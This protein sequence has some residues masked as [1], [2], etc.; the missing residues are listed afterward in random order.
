MVE[1]REEGARKTVMGT[2]NQRYAKGVPEN[3]IQ[4]L[5]SE[6][7][8]R[9]LVS[10]IQKTKTCETKYTLGG[11]VE[12]ELI[13]KSLSRARLNLLKLS[14]LQHQMLLRWFHDS[15]K[16][17]NLVLRY[18]FDHGWHKEKYLL[19][20]EFQPNK[21]K[22]MLQ[23]M[24]VSVE[25][26]QEQKSRYILLRTPK[27]IRQQ[28]VYSLVAHLKTQSTKLK[29]LRKAYP[30]KPMVKFVLKYKEK[31]NWDSDCIGIERRS[32]RLAMDGKSF[33]LYSTIDPRENL[34]PTKTRFHQPVRQPRDK[35]DPMFQVIRLAFMM[36]PADFE[37]DMKICFQKGKFYLM[38]SRKNYYWWYDP[39]ARHSERTNVCY[40]RIRKFLTIY[41]PCGSAFVIG[42]NVGN[43]LDKCIRRIDRTKKPYIRKRGSYDLMKGQ[44][45]KY[46]KVK[47]RVQLYKLRRAYHSAEVKAKNVVRDFHYKAAH[48]LCRRFSQVFFPKF[49]AKSIAQLSLNHNVKR[50]LNMLSFYKFKNRL[51]QTASLYNDTCIKTGSEAYTSKQCGLCGCLNDKLGASEI[52]NCENCGLTSD[53]DLHA[54]RNILLKY[55]I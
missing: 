29:K 9:F 28:A 20:D 23:K 12:K 17:Y 2:T 48:F 30:D 36:N 21:M 13:S 22:T 37:R 1:R 54:A 14:S 46:E 50:R 4:K 45:S 6:A 53:R 31:H 33:S 5:F 24:F 32:C 7:Y 8:C 18:V 27:T 3:H 15:R 44:M 35:K 41:S 55:L 11:E 16:T 40:W 25:G 49:N 19:S 43:V 47:K 52:F 34:G 42:S 26:I 51:V 38:C 39:Q 10:T